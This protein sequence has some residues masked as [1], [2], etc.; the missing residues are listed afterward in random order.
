MHADDKHK[1]A[2]AEI[3]AAEDARVLAQLEA[4]AQRLRE[5]ELVYGS[6]LNP[7]PAR[8]QAAALLAKRQ[9]LDEQEVTY[10]KLAAEYGGTRKARRRARAE[11]DRAA[12]KKRKRDKQA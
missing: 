11:V 12:R 4:L 7:E 5:D 10:L 9:E 1:R 2:A 8:G 3:A 6:A